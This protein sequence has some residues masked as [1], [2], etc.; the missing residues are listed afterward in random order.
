MNVPFLPKRSYWNIV[1]ERGP[2][3]GSLWPKVAPMGLILFLFGHNLRAEENSWPVPN[4]YFGSGDGYVI[5]L[6]ELDDRQV[7]NLNGNL[8][9]SGL[10]GSLRPVYE[11][12]RLVKIEKDVLVAL[13]SGGGN[14]ENFRLMM[15]WLRARAP[16]RKIIAYV[17]EG[18]QCSSACINFFLQADIRLSAPNAR[19]GFHS[20]SHGDTNKLIPG[21]A[22]KQLLKSGMDKKFLKLL[23]AQN[24]FTTKEGTYFSGADL[25]EHRIVDGLETASEEEL[26]YLSYGRPRPRSIIE[27]INLICTKLLSPIIW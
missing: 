5:S 13:D 24:V 17:P 1:K 26:N 6:L 16:K 20:A 10:S 12:L 15:K 14:S 21:F 19:F 9:N 27:E 18:A 4:S 2:K 22:E 25:K 7:L 3:L 11:A 23:I 8:N